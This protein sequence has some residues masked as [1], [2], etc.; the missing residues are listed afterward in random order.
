MNVSWT[1]EELFSVHIVMFC[2]VHWF[3]FVLAFF[4]PLFFPRSLT[5]TLSGY[6][7]MASS[8]EVDQEGTL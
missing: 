6:C 3:L 2:E 4:A 5:S 7:R 1:P 8:V